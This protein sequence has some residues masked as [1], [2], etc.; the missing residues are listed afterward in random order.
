[1]SGGFVKKQKAG[2]H[3][4]VMFTFMGDLPKEHADAWNDAILDLKQ[5]FGGNLAGVTMEGHATPSNLRKAK[6]KK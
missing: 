6:K 2:D 4:V 3:Q 5:R 1:M